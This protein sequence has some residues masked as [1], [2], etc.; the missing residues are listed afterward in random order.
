[1]L[2]ANSIKS[3]NIFFLLK[4]K[5]TTDHICYRYPWFLLSY[6]TLIIDAFVSIIIFS[7]ITIINHT[8]SINHRHHNQSYLPHHHQTC[9]LCQSM[10][11][12]STNCFLPC[13]ILIFG[14]KKIVDLE[15]NL[16]FCLIIKGESL[17]LG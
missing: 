3:C 5:F 2:Y 13:K 4:F 10:L 11:S 6:F 15:Q 14:A 9:C 16:I 8:S 7:S 1:M 17:T 12:P